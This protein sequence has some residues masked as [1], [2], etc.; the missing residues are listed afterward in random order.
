MLSFS[1]L[2]I[3]MGMFENARK[4]VPLGKPGSRDVH[5]K[6]GELDEHRRWLCQY[7]NMPLPLR[8]TAED[9]RAELTSQLLEPYLDES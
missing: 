2:A 6:L 3:L 4:F 5:I 1:Q 9:R 7:L 8:G